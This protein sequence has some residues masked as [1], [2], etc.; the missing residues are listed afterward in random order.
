M[1]LDYKKRMKGISTDQIQLFT[2][3]TAEQ[4]DKIL[5]RNGIIEK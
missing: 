4:I 2:G 5:K 1:I 3:L